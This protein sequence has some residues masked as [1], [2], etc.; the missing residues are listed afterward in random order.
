MRG[1]KGDG[2]HA[3]A[4]GGGRRALAR[5]AAL[6]VAVAACLTLAL[7]AAAGARTYCVND[8]ACV[9]TQEGSNA[10]ALQKALESAA[11]HSNEGGPDVVEVGAG[12]YSRSGGF[13]YVG[14]AV[15]IRGAGRGATVLSDPGSASENVLVLNASAS[16]TPALSELTVRVP[17]SVQN[18]T[19]IQLDSGTVEHVAIEGGGNPGGALSVTGLDLDGGEFADGS[20]EMTR[21]TTSSEAV[22]GGGGE[23]VAS[24]LVGSYG[25]Q[26]GPLTIRGCRISSEGTGVDFYNAADTIEDT[27]FDLEGR[28]GDAVIFGAWGGNDATATIRN[29]TIVNGGSES[30]GIAEEAYE[31]KSGSSTAS[32]TLS[33]SIVDHVAHPLVQTTEEAGTAASA[34]VEYSSLETSGDQAEAAKG[35][36]TPTLT[37]THAAS[38]EPDFVAPVLGAHGFAEGDWRLAPGSP[39]IDA[40]KPGALAAGEDELDL[41]G[42]PRL[43]HGRR[44]VGAYEYQWRPPSISAGASLATALVGQA[45]GFGGSASAPEPGDTIVSY[46]W[47]FDDGA[48]AAGSSA[49]HAFTAAGEHTATLSATD[50]LGLTSTAL[51]SVD[52]LAAAP[53]TPPSGCGCAPSPSSP[54]VLSGLRLAPDSFHAAS[55]G[56]PVSTHKH[57]GTKVSFTLTR[58]GTVEFRVERLLRGFS[59]GKKCL[60][61]AEG[62][63]SRRCTRRV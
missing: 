56:A 43:V 44:D 8:A 61:H 37:D 19:G 52:V 20:I 22:V 62:H 16:P 25:V 5:G 45:I 9:G 10:A 59:H 11:G 26:A 28:D 50:A 48:V 33:D 60:P 36:S 40:V 54:L 12:T 15:E 17:A 57:A 1:T 18:E 24:T 35:G 30:T 27:L 53:T 29:V 47:S 39:L 31:P 58:A 6:V 14:E 2:A 38:T 41:E 49:T 23:I 34:T 32:L 42:D 21:G 51:V 55:S 13:S 7:C 3:R 4:T 46:Q 63:T